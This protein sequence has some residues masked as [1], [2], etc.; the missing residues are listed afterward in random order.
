MVLR[1]RRTRA[2]GH[3]PV[4]LLD[5][6]STPA[7]DPDRFAGPHPPLDA[8][9]SAKSGRLERR[10][11]V[12]QDV[13]GR[14]MRVPLSLPVRRSPSWRIP[15]PWPL[16]ALAIG[17]GPLQAQACWVQA[18]QR[19]GLSPHLLVAVARVESDLEPRA[20][21]RSHLQ[22]TGSYDIGLMQINSS[23]LPTLARHGISEAQLYEPC[24]NIHVGAWLLADAFAR[25]GATWNAI[26][27]YN[28]A[29]SQLK[30]EACMAARASYAWRVYRRLSAASGAASRPV[31][32]TARRTGQAAQPAPILIAARVAP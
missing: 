8:L 9:Q 2:A 26:G 23:H 3:L 5:T 18:A 28:A 22:R 10:R 1:C 12:L 13:T 19:Y 15:G 30:G 29:C 4:D 17:W 24:T 31:E 11:P 27:A 6:R 32:A 16:V 7:P 21:N 25:H 14:S 20:V